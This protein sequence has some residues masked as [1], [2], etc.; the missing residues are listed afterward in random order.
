MTSL[1]ALAPDANGASFGSALNDA[2]L[3]A[4]AADTAGLERHAF[5]W[6]ATKG[7]ADIDTLGSSYSDAVAVGAGGEVAGSRVLPGDELL[8]RAYLWE[9]VAGMRYLGASGGVESFALN[10][11]LGARIAGVVNLASGDQRAMTWTRSEGMRQLGTL[12]GASSRAFQANDRGQVVGYANDR[13]QVSRAFLWSAKA[14]MLDLNT[15]L[16]QAPPGLVLDDALAINDAGAIV[17][18]SNA[19]LVLLAPGEGPAS[20]PVAGPV[21]APEVVGAGTVFAATVGWIDPGRVG[22]RGVRWTWGD[23]SGVQAGRAHVAEGSDAGSASASHYFA[24]PGVY[25]VTA[26]VLDRN[27][28]STSVSRTVVAAGAGMVAASGSVLSPRGAWRGAPSWVGTARFNL[29][30]PT[31]PTAP[32]ARASAPAQLSFALPGLRFH[33][34]T[35]RVLGRDGAQHVF[36]GAGALNGA[37]SVRF[38]LATTVGM[39]GAAPGRFT[40][41]IWS[42]DPVS[43]KEVVH[44]DNSK[45]LSPATATALLDGRVVTK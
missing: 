29:V 36:D 28:R 5:A 15:R 2:G 9:P 45:A 27:G 37:G 24:R 33:S 3:I 21:L 1:G 20:G 38:R 39:A 42:V 19:G 8:Y 11:S 34:A 16:R 41:R 13:N 4:G 40:L 7:L 32:D 30:A 43:G 12:G 22:I 17:A 26:T 23:G 10:M 31:L 35:L 25:R 18:S 14:G 44:Y 6:T